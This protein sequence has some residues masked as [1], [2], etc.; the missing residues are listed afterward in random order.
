M[1]K[2]IYFRIKAKAQNF[3]EQREMMFDCHLSR[4]EVMDIAIHICGTELGK[5]GKDKT[6]QELLEEIRK[7][8]LF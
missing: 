3:V 6:K 8:V 2:A 7:L 4:E 5:I 1:D